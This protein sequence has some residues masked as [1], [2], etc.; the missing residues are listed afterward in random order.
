MAASVQHI[1]LSLLREEQAHSIL[2]YNYLQFV[3]VDLFVPL[4]TRMYILHGMIP[5]S[6]TVT[7]VCDNLIFEVIVMLLC[8]S[9][10]VLPYSGKFSNGTNFRIFRMKPRHRK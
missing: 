10:T 9:H 5:F 1:A 3:E 4:I 6:N 2:S 7:Y 8:V